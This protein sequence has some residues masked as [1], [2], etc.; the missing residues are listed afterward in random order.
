MVITKVLQIKESRKLRRSL[1]YILRDDAN[2][3]RVTNNDYHSDFPYVLK[4]GQVYQR[5]VSGHDVVDASDAEAVFDD[6]FLVK[7]SAAAFNHG[8]S[9]KEMSDL[10]NPNQV[11]AHHII[12]SF[13]PE[14][15]LSPEEV[16]RLGYQTALELTGGD[17][18]FIVATHMDKGHLHN[19]IIFNTTNQ[20]TLKKFRWQK[21]TARSLFQ[22]SSRQAELAGAMV[23]E[24]KL[25][26]SYTVYSAWRQKNS[27]RFEIKQRLDFLLKHSLDL[28]DFLQKAQALNLQVNTSGQYVTYRLSDQPQERVVRDRSLSKKGRYSL[29]GITKRLATN[30]VV[31]DKD[32]IKA[33]Y[34]KVM[35]KEAEDFEM[36]LTIEPWQVETITPRSL[37]VP[38]RFG[39]DRKGTVA[40][41]AR[42][43]DQNADGSFTAYLKRKDFFY[44]LNPDHSEQN[45]FITGTT[46]IKQ[47]SS[48][49]GETILYK[50]RYLSKLDR[51]V[52]ELNFL[53]VNHVTNSEQFRDLEKNFLEQLD[54]TDQEL[55][56][57]SDKIAELNKLYGALVQYQSPLVPSETILALLEKA[58][59]DKNMN[60]D[61]LKKEL[62]EYQIEREAL[63]THRNK[64]VA[65]YDFSQ[66]LKEER[67][68][69][70]HKHL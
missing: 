49:N 26:T 32:S 61:L 54:K 36:K 8:R 28:E 30:A 60:P 20:V 17:Y 47:L 46:L 9:N 1:N 25:K 10:T 37:H 12:Q 67:Q 51:L 19:H 70:R 35:E 38:I 55:E 23:L 40:I 21:Q 4:D 62:K 3:K 63:A 53:S 11:M 6:F 59:L 57:L 2:L 65:D 64:I 15:K 58:R 39:L 5:L 33:E 29:E 66:K 50:N 44:F 69:K 43:L 45:R 13:S 14:D 52:D 22:I 27:F 48:Q 24:P 42:L 68:E 31:F 56:R 16:N 18:Q 7:D 41:P 34:D